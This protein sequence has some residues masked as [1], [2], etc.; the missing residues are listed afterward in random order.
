MARDDPP[1]TAGRSRALSFS[2]RHRVGFAGGAS[3]ALAAPDIAPGWPTVSTLRRVSPRN[4]SRRPIRTGGPL[5]SLAG[6]AVRC[7][8]RNYLG[9]CQRAR[10]V[11][12]FLVLP[13]REHHFMAKYG[14]FGNRL[15]SE[16]A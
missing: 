6:L 1:C 2:L 12:R 8:R 14:A 4:A 3:I 7:D 16:L 10:M 11:I 9:V 15:V 13:L 5:G